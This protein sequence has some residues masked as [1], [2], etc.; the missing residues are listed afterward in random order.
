MKVVCIQLN[1]G[2]EIIGRLNEDN[3]IFAGG[4]SFA[5]GTVWKPTGVVT[6]EKIRS[7]GVQQ[8][9][10]KEMGISFFPWSIANQDGAISFNLDNC[11][12]SIYPAEKA[13]EDGY[14]SQTSPIVQAHK[15]SIQM[16]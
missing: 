14:L 5:D 4:E 11:A 2:V 12:T 9:G 7:I 13:V 15:P 1:S 16:V 10:P 8:V 6:L 3:T